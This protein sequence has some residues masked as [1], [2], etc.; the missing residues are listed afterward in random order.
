MSF[1]DNQVRNRKIFNLIIRFDTD[2]DRLIIRCC[3][4]CLLGRD[5]T[6]RLSVTVQKFSS[7]EDHSHNKMI[8]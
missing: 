1:D 4:C 2:F 3:W 5:G 8:D 6:N 7:F